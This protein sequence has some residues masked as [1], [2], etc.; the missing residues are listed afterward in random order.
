MGD[1]QEQSVQ[2][3]AMFVLTRLPPH[4]SSAP[5]AEGD[6]D[7]CY[8]DL[9]RVSEPSAASA[10]GAGAGSVRIWKGR[11][12]AATAGALNL[13]QV[14]CEGACNVC[15]PVPPCT[16]I[17]EP[18]LAGDKQIE[19]AATVTHVETTQFEELQFP[20]GKRIP[21]LAGDNVETQ[22]EPWHSAVFGK[23]RVVY[24]LYQIEMETSPSLTAARTSVHL[25]GKVIA[26]P[27]EP[28]GE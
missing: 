8:G 22:L 21:I 9:I 5:L 14:C 16:I 4:G 10:P 15:P 25:G 1:G 13:V 27:V 6:G 7:F 18:K 28:I 2:G 26:I 3:D 24:H 19:I 12:H 20:N 11:H 23:H 17:G